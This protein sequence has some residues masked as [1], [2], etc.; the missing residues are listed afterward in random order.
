MQFFK[1]FIVVF[2]LSCGTVFG[3]KIIKHKVKS[4]ESIYSIARKYDVTEKEIYE[5]NPK[6]KGKVLGLKTIV[7]IQNKKYKEEEQKPKEKKKEEAVIVP[8]LP[9]S[10]EPFTIHTVSAKETLYSLSKQYGISMEAICELN[11]ELKTSNLKKG[12]KLKFP[13]TIKIEELKDQIKAPKSV[14]IPAINKEETTTDVIHKVQPKET[15]YRISK[16]YGVSVAEL[17]QLNPSITSGLP[18]GFDLVIK[19]GV[20]QVIETPKDI[21]E[22]P[23]KSVEV[24]P[25]TMENMSKADFLIAKASQHIG[26][27]YRSGGTTPGGFDCSGLMIATFQEIEMK[28][29]RTS[30]EQSNYGEP[31]DRSQAQKGD[32]IF[33]TTNGRGSINHVGMITE[34]VGD[35][36]KFIHSSIQAGVIISS[37]KEP[38][39]AT[40]FVKINRVLK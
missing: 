2:L 25:I 28:L 17:Q 10:S 20:S 34:I 29:P 27:R 30:R 9:S 18:V 14:E 16:K 6:L 1:F 12:A 37:T 40:R 26:T 31:V 19:K 39:Y 38:Y 24:A 23:V 3:Q 36:I 32:L 4:G 15:L 21:E 33:F 22:A 11:P 13:S 5:W 8:A 7:E 35:E